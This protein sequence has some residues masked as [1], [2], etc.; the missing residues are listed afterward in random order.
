MHE[1][2]EEEKRIVE[3]K[4]DKS[5]CYDVNDY[6][7][8]HFNGFGVDMELFLLANLMLKP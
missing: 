2:I 8:N 4:A 5:W 3:G 6:Y 1:Q 7:K